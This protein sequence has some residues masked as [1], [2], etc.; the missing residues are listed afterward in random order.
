[1]TRQ[2]RRLFARSCRVKS[3]RGRRSVRQE[4]HGGERYHAGGIRTRRS[5]LELIWA[6]IRLSR[7]L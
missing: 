4:K 6:A 7:R 3:R 2:G 1:M 5:H